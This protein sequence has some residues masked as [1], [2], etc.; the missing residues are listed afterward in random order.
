[1]LLIF[2]ILHDTRT[3]RYGLWNRTYCHGLRIRTRGIWRLA[4]D[5]CRNRRIIVLNVFRNWRW[6][7]DGCWT[8]RSI[9]L[10]ECQR[11]NVGYIIYRDSICVQ[12]KYIHDM[13][14]S[15]SL[16]IIK[17]FLFDM[18]EA[19]YQC[20]I[21]IWSSILLFKYKTNTVHQKN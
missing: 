19:I 16:E 6:A 15:S 9:V 18:V 1:M 11:W 14:S 2:N 8:R 13:I 20:R 21:F 12:E 4:H 17:L 7:Y 3:R 10:D 5:G